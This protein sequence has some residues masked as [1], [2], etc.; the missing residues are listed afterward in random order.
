MKILLIAVC[1]LLARETT[2]QS[3]KATAQAKATATKAA[4]IDTVTF[5][6][7]RPGDL[8]AALSR[9]RFD[10]D[11][12]FW[13]GPHGANLV[14]GNTTL[15]GYRGE[16]RITTK[17]GSLQQLSFT[18]TFR[19][20]AEAAV[21]YDKLDQEITKKFGNAS[22][23]YMNMHKSIKWHGEL[24]TLNLKTVDGSNSVTV[25]L[26]PRIVRPGTKPA[27]NSEQVPK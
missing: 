17:D 8:V 25:T 24:R 16:C 15:F 11:T 3:G 26:T 22:E 27:G 6:G 20:S 14:K 10:L 13:Y 19:D 2:A 12:I 1:L 5:D 4:K 9:V 7:I 18:S 23:A 21:A